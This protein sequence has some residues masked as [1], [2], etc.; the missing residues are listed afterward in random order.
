[1][2]KLTTKHQ[3]LDLYQV[4]WSLLPIQY[5]PSG[6]SSAREWARA[7]SD[8]QFDES[9]HRLLIKLK[10]QIREFPIREIEELE[11]DDLMRERIQEVENYFKDR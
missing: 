1:M 2:K 10:N 11:L 9:T 6:Y 5:I 8:E 3:I 4:A 7:A